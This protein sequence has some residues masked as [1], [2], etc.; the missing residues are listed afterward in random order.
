VTQLDER[1]RAVLVAASPTSTPTAD[2]VDVSYELLVGVKAAV[3]LSLPVGRE[4]VAQ[5]AVPTP[6]EPVVPD[7]VTVVA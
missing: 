2:D 4:V 7:P 1:L 6:G 5:V 3:T